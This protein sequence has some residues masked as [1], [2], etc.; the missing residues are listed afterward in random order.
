MPNKKKPKH[1]Q[2]HLHRWARID[3]AGAAHDARVHLGAAY[4]LLDVDADFGLNVLQQ[5][6]VVRATERKNLT[7][8]AALLAFYRALELVD[9]ISVLVKAGCVVAAT[10]LM[11]SLLESAMHA[12]YLMTV[13]DERVAASYII[14]Q[15]VEGLT[16]IAERAEEHAG[17]SAPTIIG[18][19]AE[20]HLESLLAE[21]RLFREARVEL[22]R[23]GL[24]RSVPAAWYEVFDGPRT[25][26]GMSGRLK[27]EYL[28]TMFERAYDRWS[29]AVHGDDTTQALAPRLHDVEDTENLLRPLRSPSARSI[30][31]IVR[32]A[33][34][35]F[36]A[37]LTHHLQYFR[38]LP[39]GLEA[40]RELEERLRVSLGEVE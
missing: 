15:Y 6:Y 38:E 4:D 12:R 17:G 28:E 40:W 14:S 19:Q 27:D 39:E 21:D 35:L 29:A 5:A 31:E 16:K 1:K 34:E 10:P 26:G 24:S 13:N 18:K 30:T 7:S 20:K 23:L 36:V 37:L 32:V 3:R 8:F 25:L 11:R 2:A 22:A 33:H 9:G